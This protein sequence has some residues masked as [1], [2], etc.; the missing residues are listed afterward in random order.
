M[1]EIFAIA[2]ERLK[3]AQPCALAT[4]VACSGSSP[5]PIGTT[6]AV[7]QTAIAGNIGAGCHEPEI[8]EACLRT[9]ADGAFR[10]VHADLSVGDELSAGAVCGAQLTVAIWKP[11]AEFAGDAAAIVR[12]ARDVIVAL[13][14][15]Y[16]FTI[17]AK[18][19][20]V[21]AGATA[22]AKQIARMAHE[23]EFFVTVGRT[24]GFPMHSIRQ[25]RCSSSH[26]IRSSTLR[27]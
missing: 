23:L 3:A 4:L 22:L 25:R 5:A 14:E 18:R 10:V 12:G 8:V 6:I 24:S 2:A 9:L 21:I 17:A 1:R 11:G 15:G 16:S 20:L 26:T 7:D 19:H 13:P 27:L